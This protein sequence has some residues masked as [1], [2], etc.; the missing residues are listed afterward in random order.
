M[1]KFKN[2][3]SSDSQFSF[4]DS[5]YMCSNFMFQTED[6]DLAEFLR[7]NSNFSEIK[8]GEVQELVEEKKSTKRKKENIE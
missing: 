8:S 1:F 7:N 5:T 3:Y 6:K 4:K 2:L